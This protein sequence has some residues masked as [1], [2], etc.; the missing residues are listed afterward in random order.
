[1]QSQSQVKSMI[2]HNRFN[3]NSSAQGLFSNQ[4]NEC[5]KMFKCVQIALLVCKSAQISGEIERFIIF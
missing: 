3:C 1:M 2:A 5:I 4:V